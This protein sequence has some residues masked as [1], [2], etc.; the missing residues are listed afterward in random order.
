MK[1]QGLVYTVWKSLWIELFNRFINCQIVQSVIMSA[2]IHITYRTPLVYAWGCSYLTVFVHLQ[3]TLFNTT[4]GYKIFYDYN[5]FFKAI[6]IFP[7]TSSKILKPLRY[8]HPKKKADKQGKWLPIIPRQPYKNHFQSFSNIFLSFPLPIFSS[9]LN[10]T[11][12]K[13]SLTFHWLNYDCHFKTVSVL[14]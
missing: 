9:S 10:M 7:S 5:C 13:F 6:H 8:K 14:V 4:R 12:H 11:C 2:K 1:L 3:E